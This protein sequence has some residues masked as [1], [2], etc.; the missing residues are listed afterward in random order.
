MNIILTHGNFPKIVV[1]NGFKLASVKRLS[2]N[3]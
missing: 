2:K 1:R 3:N